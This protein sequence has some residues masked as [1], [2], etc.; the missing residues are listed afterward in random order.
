MLS[1]FFICSNLLVNEAIAASIIT[2]KYSTLN[3]SA[4]DR[5]ISSSLSS[6][7]SKCFSLS[8]TF[9]TKFWHYIHFRCNVF[10]P[11]S[12][13]EVKPS[14]LYFLK[15]DMTPSICLRVSSILTILDCNFLLTFSLFACW[16]Q[17]AQTSQP[18]VFFSHK[19]PAPANPNQHQHL[20]TNRPI[21]SPFLS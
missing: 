12:I 5:C 8:L 4:A 1:K 10:F 6:G 3:E 2:L 14:P 19:K 13:L 11:V 17:P 20:P 16:F 15:Y 7:S 18:T 9:H 21:I